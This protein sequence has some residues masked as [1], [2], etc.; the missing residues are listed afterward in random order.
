MKQFSSAILLQTFLVVASFASAEEPSDKGAEKER[1]RSKPVPKDLSEWK[2]S[3]NIG[4]DSPE[5]SRVGWHEIDID[6]DRRCKIVKVRR[7]EKS[8]LFDE[9]LPAE[10]VATILN[11]ARDAINNGPP[12]RKGAYWHDGEKIVLQLTAAGEKYE[13]S[14]DGLRVRTDLDVPEDAGPEIQ[15]LVKLINGHLSPTKK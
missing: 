4:P 5:R 12:K 11:L 3:L 10:E 15:K 13:F 14:R 6:S 9:K 1:P 8:V 2:L 7:Q